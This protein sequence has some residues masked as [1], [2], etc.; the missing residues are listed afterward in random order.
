MVG[1]DTFKFMNFSTS[2]HIFIFM[3]VVYFLEY[4]VYVCVC[5]YIYIYIAQEQDVISC[6]Y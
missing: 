5:V 1:E 6:K 2:Q 4:N 3:N